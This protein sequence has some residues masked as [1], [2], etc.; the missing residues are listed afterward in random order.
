MNNNI[1][2]KAIEKIHNHKDLSL[3]TNKY[4]KLVIKPNYKD[5]REFSENLMGVEMDT[6][7]IKMFKSKIKM[8][9]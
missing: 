3:V 8:I 6:A 5:D 2:G 1:F 4:L 7:N 9:G